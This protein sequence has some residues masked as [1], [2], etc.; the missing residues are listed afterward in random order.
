MVLN[1]LPSVQLYKMRCIS[2]EDGVL[3]DSECQLTCKQ[4]QLVEIVLLSIMQLRPTLLM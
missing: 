2:F 1:R 4:E 3:L